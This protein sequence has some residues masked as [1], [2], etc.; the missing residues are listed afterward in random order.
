MERYVIHHVSGSEALST[1]EMILADPTRV[2]KKASLFMMFGVTR[3]KSRSCIR[4]L[5][6]NTSPAIN[7][8]K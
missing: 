8:R 3:I 1:P 2:Q 4:M 5:M 7:K 6:G